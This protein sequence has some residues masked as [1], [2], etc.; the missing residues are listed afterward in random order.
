MTSSD[1]AIEKVSGALAKAGA[2]T[3]AHRHKVPVVAKSISPILVDA[4]MK[5]STR[6]GEHSEEKRLSDAN[7]EVHATLRYEL[8]P[9]SELRQSFL[10]VAVDLPVRKSNTSSWALSRILLPGQF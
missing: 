1:N 8:A 3:T 6:R 7:A 9:G 4:A 2:T 5:L 10:P